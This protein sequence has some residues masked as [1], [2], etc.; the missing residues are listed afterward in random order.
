M[1]FVPSRPFSF[2]RLSCIALLVA[3]IGLASCGGDDDNPPPAPKQ[4]DLVGVLHGVLATSLQDELGIGAPL[5]DMAAAVDTL[6]DIVLLSDPNGIHDDHPALPLL[7]NALHSGRAVV[8]ENV[9]A[10]EVNAL[11]KALGLRI[12]GFTLPEGASVVELFAVRKV[13]GD[14]WFFVD[15]GASWEPS[16]GDDFRNE[17]SFHFDKDEARDYCTMQGD[18]KPDEKITACGGTSS[19]S[20]DGAEGTEGASQ[21]AQCEAATQVLGAPR[22]LSPTLVKAIRAGTEPDEEADVDP[23]CSGRNPN[24][25]CGAMR[26]RALLDWA[27]RGREEGMR[28]QRSVVL[29][30]AGELNDPASKTLWEYRYSPGGRTFTVEYEISSYHSFEEDVDYYF[31]AQKGTFDP[32]TFAPGSSPNWKNTPANCHIITDWN[33]ASPSHQYGYI[34][35][36]EFEH[37]LP[38]DKGGPENYG[39]TNH[40][41]VNATYS[42]QNES[43]DYQV[44]VGTEKSVGGSVGFSLKGSLPTAV[45]TA[46]ELGAEG[47]ASLSAG[48]SKSTSSTRTYSDSTLTFKATGRHMSGLSWRYDFLRPCRAGKCSWLTAE[49]GNLQDATRLAKGAFS[50]QQEWTWRVPSKYSRA[51]FLNPGEGAT[52]GTQKGFR[53]TFEAMTGKSKGYGEQLHSGYPT[54]HTCDQRF[55]TT[56]YVPVSRPPLLALNQSGLN[57][58]PVGGGSQKVNL[59]SEYAWKVSDKP[60][61]VTVEPMSGEPTRKMSESEHAGWNGSTDLRV[62]VYKDDSFN[63]SSPNRSGY[64]KLCATDDK[65]DCAKGGEEAWIKVTQTPFNN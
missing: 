12:S 57:D 17:H 18:E 47:S 53:T 52:E 1:S 5:T 22:A 48:I 37:A 63:E 55:K 14:T 42:P 49:F 23:E 54:Q 45:P 19:G 7:K 24:S 26:S 4:A 20:A 46:G 11:I 13:R 33:D 35:F 41:V 38:N 8:L 65:G 31:I 39:F 3:G 51:Y 34:R 28:A 59:A 64:V 36:Y 15:L 6:Q 43:K 25:V 2:P 32:S 27:Q 29:R 16:A 62:T 40:D 44:T 9:N 30:D 50:P 58:F 61:W 56:F 60:G 10:D 21:S